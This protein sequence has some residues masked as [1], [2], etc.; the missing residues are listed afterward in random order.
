M[1][2]L[3]SLTTL[4]VAMSGSAGAMDFKPSGSLTSFNRIGF[5]N[6]PMNVKENLYPTES[7]GTFIVKAQVDADFLSKEQK[8]SGQSFTGSIGI[9][10]GGL[11]YDNSRRWGNADFDKNFNLKSGDSVVGAWYVIANANIYNLYG[12]YEIR[13]PNADGTADH[14]FSIKGGRYESSAEFMYAYTQGFELDYKYKG[15]NLWWYS[16]FGRAFAEGSWMYPWYNPK[17]MNNVNYGIHIL[18]LS[19]TFKSGFHIQPYVYISPD[20]Y[21]APILKLIY[22]SNPNF[23]KQGVRSKTTVNF[24]YVHHTPAAAK[25][26]RYLAIAGHDAQTLNFTEQVDINNYYIAAG[27]YFNFGNANAQLGTYGNPWIPW[28]YWSSTVYQMGGMTAALTKNAKSGYIYVGGSH[29]GGKLEWRIL[30]RITRSPF[31]NEASIP[32]NLYY[33]VNKYFKMWFK[34]EWQTATLHKGYVIALIPNN[35]GSYYLPGSPFKA[36]K[37][38]TQD[39]SNFMFSFTYSF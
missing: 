5:N 35:P 12:R 36:T 28:N 2:K 21:V 25:Q 24:M 32:F 1:K 29:L 16:S 17:Q 8:E 6:A 9:F 20:F 27:G 31:E 26:W 37:N 33:T 3:S 34:L 18:Q 11:I 7:W 30:G 4:L 22:D 39:R 13:K 10:A 23:N 19:Y 14:V 38:V 15:L